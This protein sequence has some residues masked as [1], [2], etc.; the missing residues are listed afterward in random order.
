M[1]NDPLTETSI[2]FDAL[3]KNNPA[4]KAAMLAVYDAMNITLKP[5]QTLIRNLFGHDFGALKATK[6]PHNKPHITQSAET[7]KKFLISGFDVFTKFS[8]ADVHL[9]TC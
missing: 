6:W 9:M 8:A 1:L 2:L 7:N 5:P 4:I 3:W